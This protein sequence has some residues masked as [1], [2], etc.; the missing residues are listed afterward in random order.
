[1]LPKSP[2]ITITEEGEAIGTLRQFASS[3]NLSLSRLRELLETDA[4]DTVIFC[5]GWTPD[6]LLIL[7]GCGISVLFSASAA[8]GFAAPTL[9]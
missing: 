5:A 7:D 2:I 1:M 3:L 6:R 8:S 4:R 9:H